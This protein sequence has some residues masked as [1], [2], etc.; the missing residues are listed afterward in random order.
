M[1]SNSLPRSSDTVPAFASAF[2]KQITVVSALV[3]REMHTRYGR[4]NLGFIWMTLEPLL[5]GLAVV[6][7]WSVARGNTQHGLP[8]LTF[9]L[10]GYVPFMIWRQFLGRSVKCI[11]SNIGLLYH[12]HVRILDLLYARFVLELFGVCNA[13]VVAAFFFW[14]IDLYKLPVD[15]GLF[16]LGWFYLAVSSLGVGLIM[17]AVTEMYDWAG[18][19]VGPI[20]FISY[21]L[22]GVFFM[23]EWLPEKAREVLIWMPTVNAFEMI[24]G[25]QFGPAVNVYYDVPLAS[26]ICLTLV[27]L[28][29]IM[30]RNTHRHLVLG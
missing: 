10:T 28:G 30:C 20:V 12:R 17:S 13:F 8:V 14:A 25:G 21:P 15:F 26:I 11:S 9:V 5:L 27:F 29:L 7:L 6:A 2:R 22:S 24:R 19:L 18:K 3:I 4:E 1:N 23:L 16:Y